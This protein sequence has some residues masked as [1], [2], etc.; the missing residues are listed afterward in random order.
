MTSCP[1]PH[2][3]SLPAGDHLK[4]HNDGDIAMKCGEGCEA[5]CPEW[6]QLNIRARGSGQTA[7]HHQAALTQTAAITDHEGTG[8]RC[9]PRRSTT[10]AHISA[11]YHPDPVH[12]HL[13]AGSLSQAEPSYHSHDGGVGLDHPVYVQTSGSS[14]G[15]DHLGQRIMR[16]NIRDRTPDH[17][18][19]IQS[20][21]KFLLRRSSPS[22]FGNRGHNSHRS[23][24]GASQHTLRRSPSARRPPVHSLR[25]P[26]R[27]S[28]PRRI[29]STR[30]AGDSGEA[31]GQ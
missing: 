9:Q 2:E 5:E 27:A 30:V 3:A 10:H 25:P 26:P 20:P 22:G 11:Q 29:S 28:F 31:I 8:L 6:P 18:R 16:P 4:N 14:A 19:R 13:Q 21:E 15:D 12:G 23:E 17:N 24:S 7:P 1:P